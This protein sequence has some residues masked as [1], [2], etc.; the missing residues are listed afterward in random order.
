MNEESQGA[1]VALAT[2]VRNAATSQCIF[3]PW[4]GCELAFRD[5]A[6]YRVTPNTSQYDRQYGAPLLRVEELI[7]MADDEIWQ[8]VMGANG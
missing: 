6:L 2:A 8:R 7:G 3:L 1:Q 4:S 5:G